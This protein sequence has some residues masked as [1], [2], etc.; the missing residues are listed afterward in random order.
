MVR[1]PPTLEIDLALATSARPDRP[2]QHF[3]AMPGSW[4]ARP[5]RRQARSTRGRARLQNACWSSSQRDFARPSRASSCSRP[6]RSLFAALSAETES[7]HRRRRRKAVK[8]AAY[9][10][11]FAGW[12]VRRA[13]GRHGREPRADDHGLGWMWR[14][15]G[16]LF[17]RTARRATPASAVDSPHCAPRGRRIDAVWPMPDL[18]GRPRT[19]RP[20]RRRRRHHSE[21]SASAG[22]AFLRAPIRTRCGDGARPWAH[23]HPGRSPLEGEGATLEGG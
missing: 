21:T 20:R 11:R 12:V 3:L 22:N 19:V 1:P 9:H 17:G 6:G 2:G 4:R 15:T 10:A 8:E 14:F 16:E 23:P 13:T 18:S 7:D 5:R